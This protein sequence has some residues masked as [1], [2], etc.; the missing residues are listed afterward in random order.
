M[1]APETAQGDFRFRPAWLW[2][3]PAVLLAAA[4]TLDAGLRVQCFLYLPFY[5]LSLLLAAVIWLLVQ[6]ARQENFQPGPWIR[7]HG[8][9]LAA[10]LLFAAVLFIAVPPYYRVLSDETNMLSVSRSLTFQR[11]THNIIQAKWTHLNER[12]FEFIYEKRPFLYPWLVSLAHRFLGFRAENAFVVNGLALG[13]LFFLIFFRLRKNF[14]PVIAAAGVL[15]AAAQPV[16]TQTAASAG[17]DMTYV[18]FLSAS[19]LAL[20]AFLKHE[21]ATRFGLLWGCLLLLANT[22]Y[23]G[24]LYLLVVMA[25]LV[26]LGKVRREYFSQSFIYPM[27]PLLL[28]PTWWQRVFM[29][30]DLQIP[31]GEKAFALKYFFQNNGIFLKTLFSFEYFLPHANL[32]DLLG[33]AGLIWMAFQLARRRWPAQTAQRQTALV[34]TAVIF[35]YWVVMTAH[36]GTFWTDPSGCRVMS[37]GALVLSLAALL[38]LTKLPWPGS[39]GDAVLALTAVFFFLYHPVAIKNYFSNGMVLT[40]EYRYVL[41]FLKTRNPVNAL[42]ITN[43]P[44]HYTALGRGGIKFTYANT[45]RDHLL[46][47]YHQHLFGEVLVVQEVDAVTGAVTEDTVLDP[48]FQLEPLFEL[49]HK[50]GRFVRISR[51]VNP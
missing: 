22:R 44:G 17:I 42:I 20:E 3:V 36:Y 6:G 7:R 13:G 49:D 18:L 27:T 5:L 10:C 16:L 47:Q 21:S 46:Q 30:T 48:A 34:F 39:R 9:A 28:L 1:K 2:L 8:P 12:P 33:V 51:V 45:N 41:E 14:S 50:M 31:E 29:R 43:V 19:L 35:L 40:R 4:T 26:V 24:P 37:F 32:V 11:S 38:F 23:E 25:A 15:L